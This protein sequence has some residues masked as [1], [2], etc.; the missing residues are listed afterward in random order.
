M[1]STQKNFVRAVPLATCLETCS[2]AY[3]ALEMVWNGFSLA[4]DQGAPNVGDCR[5]FRALANRP[6]AKSQ[7]DRADLICMIESEQS[8]FLRGILQ[9]NVSKRR[10][11]RAPLQSFTGILRF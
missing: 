7:L 1:V 2:R 6:G 3:C 10:Q 11:G 4:K 9:W 5:I 8:D